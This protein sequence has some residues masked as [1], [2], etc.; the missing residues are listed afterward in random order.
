MATAM[1]L[2]W[3]RQVLV[4]FQALLSVLEVIGGNEAVVATHAA[5]VHHGA[6]VGHLNGLP[7]AGLPAFNHAQLVCRVI[8]AQRDQL[9]PW[10]PLPARAQGGGG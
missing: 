2:L 5:L 8:Y 1:A 6:V 9:I 7:D 3:A 4:F 10:Q